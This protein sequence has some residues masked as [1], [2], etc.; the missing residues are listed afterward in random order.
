MNVIP[1]CAKF[2]VSGVIVPLSQGGMPVLPAPAIRAEII[3]EN[4]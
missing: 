2:P 1:Q 4:P 3:R